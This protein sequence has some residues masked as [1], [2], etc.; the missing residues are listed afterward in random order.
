[1][2]MMACGN[3]VANRRVDDPFLDI[4]T[5]FRERGGQSAGYVTRPPAGARSARFVLIYRFPKRP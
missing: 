4:C 1:M 2:D 3:M 5:A